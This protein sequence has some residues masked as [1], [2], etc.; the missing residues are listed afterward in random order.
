MVVAEPII[1]VRNL[2]VGYHTGVGRTI[3]AVRDVN[4]D[5]YPGQSLALVGESGCGK[6]TLGL[7]LLRLLPRLGFIAEGEV[8]FRPEPT[9]ESVDVVRLKGKALR[10][11]RWR[12]VAMV[13][14]GA[15]NAF[16][17]VL[18]IGEQFADTMRA[19]A[20]KGNWS[21]TEVRDIS[22]AKLESVRLDPARVLTSYPHELSGGMRQRALIALSLILEPRVLILDEPTTALDLLT[23]RS[24]VT[25]LHELRRE[26]GFTVIFISHDLPLASELSDRVATMYAGRIIEGGT[27]HDIFATPRHPYTAG[28]IKASPPVHAESAEPISIPGTPPDLANLPVGCS[29]SPRCSYAIEKCHTQAPETET[30]EQRLEGISHHV[31]CFKWHDVHLADVSNWGER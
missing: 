4:F 6:S 31:E 18:K 9:A 22:A 24:I 25:M 23:Q 28:L 30:I 21:K 26:L 14:Q 10:Q 19:H 3:Q 15:M 5:L 12:E 29:F 11:W 17:P 1:S 7:A 16:N 20:G 2:R 13:F 8:Q 27:T